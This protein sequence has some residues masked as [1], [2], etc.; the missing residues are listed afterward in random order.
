MDRMASD[1]FQHVV[2]SLRPAHSWVVQCLPQV[3]K[4]QGRS[5]V[6][7]QMHAQLQKAGADTFLWDTFEDPAHDIVQTKDAEK[8]LEYIIQW[9]EKRA[10]GVAKSK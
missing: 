6:P 2:Y 9:V 10:A 1:W 3:R 7:K 5:V 4:G 8:V